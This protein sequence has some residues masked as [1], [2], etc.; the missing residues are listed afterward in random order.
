MSLG[1]ILCERHLDSGCISLIS[2]EA[3]IG[4]FS[5]GIAHRDGNKGAIAM[6]F[7]PG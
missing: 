2:D 1:V 6:C 5:V 3:F 4:G 7:F